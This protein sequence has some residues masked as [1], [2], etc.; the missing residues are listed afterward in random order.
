MRLTF[1]CTA[2]KN[3]KN[4]KNRLPRDPS[5]ESVVIKEDDACRATGRSLR[6]QAATIR[7][8]KPPLTSLLPWAAWRAESAMQPFFAHYP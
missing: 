8:R 7:D 6:Q 2:G 3:K 4:P 5:R 1:Y